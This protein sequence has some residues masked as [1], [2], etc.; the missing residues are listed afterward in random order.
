MEHIVKKL[1][2]LLLLGVCVTSATNET[3]S[4][5]DSAS[6]DTDTL[7]PDNTTMIQDETVRNNRTLSAQNTPRIRNWMVKLP[8]NEQMNF[9]RCQLHALTMS[10]RPHVV[11]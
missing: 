8:I 6:N 1:W 9:R 11:T 2:I 3:I 4:I 5:S 10:C 7:V